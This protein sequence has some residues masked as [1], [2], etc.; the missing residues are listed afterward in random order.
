MR[1]SSS[2]QRRQQVYNDEKTGGR[3]LA[4]SFSLYSCPEPVMANRLKVEETAVLFL[5]INFERM[6]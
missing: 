1:R 5:V 6:N 2:P 3:F 4:V